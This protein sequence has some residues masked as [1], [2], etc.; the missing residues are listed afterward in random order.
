MLQIQKKK[1]KVE[2]MELFS[3]IEHKRHT[4]ESKTFPKS[5]SKAVDDDDIIRTK[6][7]HSAGVLI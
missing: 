5:K 1:R 4:R 7:N 2:G 3:K 6:F